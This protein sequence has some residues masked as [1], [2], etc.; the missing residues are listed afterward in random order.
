MTLNATPEC[1]LDTL[2]FTVGSLPS[3]PSPVVSYSQAQSD[4][5]AMTA[6]SSVS[7]WG[8][9]LASQTFSTLWQLTVDGTPSGDHVVA[10]LGLNAWLVNLTVGA[11][12]KVDYLGQAYQTAGIVFEV[13]GVL[14]VAA[15]IVIA[16]FPRIRA[17][18]T[19][20]FGKVRRRS[21]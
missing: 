3:A 5:L 2:A 11:S 14:L 17:R 6:V 4:P 15:S 1:R 16:R 12:L 7:G 10:N 8:L 13:A 21:R 18:L 9:F 20:A 19:S